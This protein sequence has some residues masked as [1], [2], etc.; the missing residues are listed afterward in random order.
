M[1]PKPVGQAVQLSDVLGLRR[2]VSFSHAVQVS[3][4]TPV[5]L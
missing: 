5:T 3:G 4:L 1:L 2:N